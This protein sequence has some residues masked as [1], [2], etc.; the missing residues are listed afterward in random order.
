VDQLIGCNIQP[1]VARPPVTRIEKFKRA[2]VEAR[3][4]IEDYCGL[5][6]HD[7]NVLS[8]ETCPT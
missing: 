2:E 4:A 8:P 5:V 1:F 3:R 6:V 7:A